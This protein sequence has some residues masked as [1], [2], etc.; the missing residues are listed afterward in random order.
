MPVIRHPQPH[1]EHDAYLI[2]QLAADDLDP[3]ARR[4]AQRLVA[5]CPHCAE[6]LAEMRAI[7]V[8]T[9][10]LPPPIRTRDFRL[11]PEDAVRL[12]SP[13]RAWLGRLGQPRFAFTQPLGAA[14]ASLGLAGLLLGVLPNLG[15]S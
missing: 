4:E 2:A 9:S 15:F 11:T 12:R 13:W 6:L 3:A 8:A 5:E 10:E 1:V 14:L 7:S